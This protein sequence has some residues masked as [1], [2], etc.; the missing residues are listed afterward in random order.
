M[1]SAWDETNACAREIQGTSIPA[2]EHPFPAF[3]IVVRALWPKKTA[4]HLAAAAGVTERCAKYWLS[5][6][7]APSMAAFMAVLERITGRN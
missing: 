7:R 4:A 6:D 5:G 3:V 1:R 2:G